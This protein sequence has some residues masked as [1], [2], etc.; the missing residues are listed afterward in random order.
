MIPPEPGRDTAFPLPRE[1]PFAPPPDYERLRAEQPVARVPM[2]GGG[3]AWLVSRHDEARHAL[4]DPGLSA[5]RRRS[6]FPRLAPV[7]E[8]QRQDSFRNFR[9]PLN[10]MDPPEHAAARRLVI[11]EFTAR[12][13]NSWRPRITEIVDECLDAMVAGGRP[14]DLVRSL[15]YPVP[16]R[17]ICELLGVPYGWH[18]FFEERT[19]I[20]LNRGTPAPE[21]TRCAREIRGMLDEVVADKARHPADDLLTRLIAKLRARDGEDHEFVVSMAFVLLV[22]GH[23]TTSNMISLGVLALLEHPSQLARTLADPTRIPATVEELLRY[24]TIVVAATARVAVDDIEIGGVRIR[25]GEGVVALIQAANRDPA[26]F[27]DPGALDVDR[28][29]RRH[30]AFGHG[31]HQCL[32]QNLARLEL[33]LVLE[34]LFRRLPGLRTA[35]PVDELKFKVDANVYGLHQ[36]PVTW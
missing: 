15:A 31:R 6:G 33:Q 3:T 1:C 5:D 32:G 16:S 22:A 19:T 10:W 29:A 2:V 21:R 4:A 36:L 23:V 28:G 26:V 34:R 13:V 18:E 27:A 35:V 20:M 14:V 17:V 8:T 9:A 11:D 30:L 7:T 24:L 12:R 25:A